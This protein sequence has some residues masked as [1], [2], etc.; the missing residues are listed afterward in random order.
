MRRFV[1]FSMLLLLLSI[2]LSAVGP[3]VAQEPVAIDEAEA[4]VEA[5]SDEA[6]AEAEGEH[7]AVTED[8]PEVDSTGHSDHASA[9]G[10]TTNTSIALLLTGMILFFAVGAVAIRRL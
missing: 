4:E 3:L 7:P 6:E 5:G 1:H 2:A 9:P 10:A 8:A